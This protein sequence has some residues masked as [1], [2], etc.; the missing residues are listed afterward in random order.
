MFGTTTNL[1]DELRTPLDLDKSESV[2]NLSYLTN[3][4][5][6]SVQHDTAWYSMIQHGTAW[7]SMMYVLQATTNLCNQSIK[8][9]IRS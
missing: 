1:P 9:R 6:Q 3:S 5:W 8:I 2:I 7:Y 4:V